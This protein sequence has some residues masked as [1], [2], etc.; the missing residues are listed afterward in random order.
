MPWK[1]WTLHIINRICIGQTLFSLHHPNTV[2]TICMPVYTL[3]HSLCLCFCSFSLEYPV[4]SLHRRGNHPHFPLPPGLSTENNHTRIQ[5]VWLDKNK[6][7][8][9]EERMV[10][11]FTPL[12]CKL[13]FKFLLFY[14]F[15]RFFLHL[16]KQNI[17]ALIMHDSRIIK[18][19]YFQQ[20]L[21]FFTDTVFFLRQAVPPQEGL[22]GCGLPWGNLTFRSQLGF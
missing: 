9:C 18:Y 1:H 19:L 10:D 13:S 12:S 3:V 7:N 17:H 22:Q 5:K 2:Y 21:L 16:P 6:W 4:Q 14:L 11:N 15:V 20:R 8:I